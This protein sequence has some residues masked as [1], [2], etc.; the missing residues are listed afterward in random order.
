M[1][2]KMRI[3]ELQGMVQH[4]GGVTFVSQAITLTARDTPDSAPPAGV[5]EV[6]PGFGTLEAIWPQA[7]S[8]TP[9]WTAWNKAVENAAIQAVNTVHRRREE[10]G[11]GLERSCAAWRR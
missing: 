1:F 4:I 3:D 10:A 5:S 8:T 7:S 2:I 9:Q 11:A 6:T